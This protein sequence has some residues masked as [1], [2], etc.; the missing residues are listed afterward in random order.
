MIDPEVK[1]TAD[2]LLVFED[3]ANKFVM[4]LSKVY[5]ARSQ[6]MTDSASG[7]LARAVSQATLVQEAIKR[8]SNEMQLF[9]S[10]A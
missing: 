3:A 6:H 8:A 7:H 1:H 9:T 10:G 2:E 4:V 5:S